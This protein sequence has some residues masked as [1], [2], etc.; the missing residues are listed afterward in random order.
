MS[1]FS[2]LLRFRPVDDYVGFGEAVDRQTDRQRVAYLLVVSMFGLFLEVC[3][4]RW[5]GTEFRAAAF[6]KNVSLLACFLGLGLGFS[7]ADRRKSYFPLALPMLFLH[8]FVFG[9]LSRL[10]VDRIIRFPRTGSS[11][12]VW[13]MDTIDEGMSLSVLG[14][15]AVFYGFFLALFVTT[16][17]VFIPIGQVTG[18]VMKSFSP[19]R[20]YSIN[21]AGSIGGVLLFTAVSFLWLPPVVWFGLASLFAWYLLRPSGVSLARSVPFVLAILVWVGVDWAQIVRPDHPIMQHVYSPYQHLELQP[22]H[23]VD[24]KGRRL[25]RG[26]AA[27]A[28]KSYHLRAADLSKE[29]ISAHGENF[30]WILQRAASYDLPY[31]F[32]PDAKNVLVL[33]SGAGND[34]AAAIRNGHP[35]RRIDAVE[36]DPAIIEFG[37]N[38]HPEQPY[39]HPQVTV[40]T[41]DA[42]H[43]VAGAEAKY[44]LIVFGLIDSHT[45]LSG[46]SSL[47]LE[48]FV[49]TRQGFA[50]ARRSLREGGSLAVSFCA[51]PEA[52]VSLRLYHMLRGLFPAVRAFHIGADGGTVFIAGAA[53]NRPVALQQSVLDTE[54]TEAFEARP[55]EA[56]PPDTTDDWPF[57]YMSKR[58]VPACHLWLLL[59]LGGVSVLWVRVSA[60]SEFKFNA[61]F[62]LLG[63]AFLLIETKGITELAL[64]WGTTWLV[65]S[66]VITAV[67]VFVLLANAYV[68]RRTP[69]R[70]WPYY[71]GL[72]VTLIGGYLFSIEDMLSINWYLAAATSG[73]LLFVPLF[74]AGVVFAISLK[75][76][77]SI[78]EAFASNLMGAIVGGLCEYSSMA[79][80]FRAMYLLALFLYAASYWALFRRRIAA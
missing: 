35:D 73:V 48:H 5:H 43:F 71:L 26:M 50:D 9:L 32:C 54:V 45:L 22:F 40:H 12:W 60:R 72:A 69:K 34:V 31:T 47:R 80:G 33:G 62:F 23:V 28:N 49:Y 61:H 65:N 25:N 19:I 56:F 74:F 42:R 79:L 7:I 57:L 52:T 55:P 2:Q 63:A 59:M 30:D 20:A 10:N 44:D 24:A 66:V 18:R 3:L 46:M 58:E 38:H 16:I 64:V 27:F 39:S 78:S 29:W 51:K 14:Q 41:G 15:Y 68:V 17:L 8:L 75:A 21:I 1:K 4:I 13:G 37:R 77:G 36:I 6:F 11:L 76:V 70:V 53:A 67:L